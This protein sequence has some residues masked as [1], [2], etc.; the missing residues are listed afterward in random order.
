MAQ[1]F[2]EN[3][4]R[5]SLEPARN[6]PS[7][8]TF[9]FLTIQIRGTP[10]TLVGTTMPGSETQRGNAPSALLIYKHTSPH[11]ER[12]VP[13]VHVAEPGKPSIKYQ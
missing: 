10:T 1:R 3:M 4:F 13:S 2:E 7:V 8:Y 11:S 12:H 9:D 6:L 5:L